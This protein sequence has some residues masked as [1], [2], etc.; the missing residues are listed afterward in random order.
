MAHAQKPDLVFQR[1]GRVHLNWRRGGSVQSITG[2]RGVRISG[3]NGSNAGYTMFWGRVQDY[4]LPT[5]LACFPFTSRTV[6]HRVPSGFIWAL[7]RFRKNLLPL[8]TLK[9]W[10]ETFFFETLVSI[11]RST[12]QQHSVMSIAVTVHKIDQNVQLFAPAGRTDLVKWL[13][14]LTAQAGGNE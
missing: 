4:W 1:N 6:H 8:S 7:P 9:I 11:Y 5:P 14:F 13:Q 10:A 12:R 2:S 3:S